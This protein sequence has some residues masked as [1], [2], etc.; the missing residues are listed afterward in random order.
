MTDT[1]KI[2]EPYENRVTAAAVEWFAQ[3]K[4]GNL[5]FIGYESEEGPQYFADFTHN[6]HAYYP[7]HAEVDHIHDSRGALLTS[8]TQLTD[9]EVLFIVGQGPW[10][11]FMEKEGRI[12]RDLTALPGNHLK[13]ICFL[14]ISEDFNR[15]AREGMEVLKKSL[16]RPDIAIETYNADFRQFAQSGNYRPAPNT[17]VISTGA[18]ISN[19]ENV[20][21]TSFP[22]AQLKTNLR[23]LGNIAGPG[24][25]LLLGYDGNTKPE[26][27]IRA[28]AGSDDLSKFFYNMLWEIHT[29]ASGLSLTYL[30]AQGQRVPFEHDDLMAGKIVK[31]KPVWNQNASHI[32]HTL[33]FLVPVQVVADMDNPKL[34]EIAEKAGC[35]NEIDG[36]LTFKPGSSLIAMTSTKFSWEDVRD[37][38]KLAGL[39]TLNV[40]H[41][42]TGLCLHSFRMASAGSDGHDSSS[43][44]A[45][46]SRHSANAAPQNR[47]AQPQDPCA[48]QSRFSR[49]ISRFR[50]DF[51]GMP[52]FA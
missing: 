11:N 46:A 26:A 8:K 42:S 10:Q 2:V 30:N 50:P 5:D 23:A 33:E 51:S 38:G 13:K 6:H 45:A 43:H 17:T 12:I 4:L 9:T 25:T 27:N 16:N 19:I 52:N 47:A 35:L 14:D 21:Q 22:Q 41:H 1:V 20:P 24:G 44:Q 31:Y 29:K 18:L 37:A 39:D 49:I 34:R 40:Y 32:A 7:Y 36:G 15:Q 3:K 48:G 28:Y